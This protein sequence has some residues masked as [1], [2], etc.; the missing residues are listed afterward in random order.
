MGKRFRCISNAVCCLRKVKPENRSQQ[1][2]ELGGGGS[3][4]AVRKDIHGTAGHQRKRL[5]PAGLATA[6]AAVLTSLLVVACGT[7]GNPGPNAP[8]SSTSPAASGA[9]P[10]ASSAVS[11]SAPV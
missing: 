11:S 8:A 3:M 1:V 6:G 7:A 2:S 9:S 4:A 10:A 5:I